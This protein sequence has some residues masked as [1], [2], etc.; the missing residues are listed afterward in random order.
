MPKRCKASR[1][2]LATAAPKPALCSVALMA[3]L[4]LGSSSMTRMCLVEIGFVLSMIFRGELEALGLSH[5]AFS[6]EFYLGL[7]STARRKKKFYPRELRC[8][9]ENI[10]GLCGR[11]RILF[12]SFSLQL[13]RASSR[14]VGY[15]HD[16]T[17]QVAAVAETARNGETSI[18]GNIAHST[19]RPSGTN[20][21]GAAYPLSMSCAG[22][23]SWN[24]FGGDAV[25][26]KP[27]RAGREQENGWGRGKERRR[28]AGCGLETGDACC[29]EVSSGEGSFPADS[30]G[31]Y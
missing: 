3:A 6:F 14:R 19:V 4:T 8:R 22:V 26:V 20:R 11:L 29:G 18:L 31:W 30:D 17:E 23:I 2:S 28:R 9:E 1:R 24:H 21:P 16:V 25:G 15:R 10:A 27:G 7:R 5:P 13:S 12:C